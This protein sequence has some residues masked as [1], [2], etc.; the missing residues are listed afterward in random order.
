M[1]KCKSLKKAQM[2]SK[3]EILELRQDFK[4]TFAYFK[5][6]NQRKNNA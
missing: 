6:L 2:L 4:T 5:Q 3:K 1:K